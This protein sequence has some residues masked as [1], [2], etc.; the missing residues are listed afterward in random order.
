M[1][2]SRSSRVR[3]IAERQRGLITRRQALGAGMSSAAVRYAT[4][5]QVWQPLLPGI[6]ATFSGPVHA[7]HRTVAALLYVGPDAVL[8][9]PLACRL[10]GL[11]YGPESDDIDVAIPSTQRVRSTG[12]IG[13]HRTDRVPLNTGYA[14]QDDGGIVGPRLA[15]VGAR[16]PLVWLRSPDLVPVMPPARAGLDTVS[17]RK[18]TWSPYRMGADANRRD[19]AQYSIGGRRLD[20]GLLQDTRALLCESV[21]RRLCGPGQLLAELDERDSRGTAHARRA[22]EDITAGCRSAPECELRDL[23]RSSRV[24]PEPHWNEPLP[25]EPRLVPDACWPEARL[26]VEVDS[27]AWHGFGNSPE[28]TE[29]RRASLAGRGWRVLPIA[30]TRIRRE[31]TAVLTEIE[32]AYRAGSAG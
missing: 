30:P 4:N 10:H 12:F 1:G 16:D 9:G 19:I 28:M 18:R 7:S 2:S 11:T 27:R 15:P 14:R 29:R 5:S 24:L 23:I 8:T 13:V 21:Q 25:G 31:S 20:A 22:L 6:Y 3:R 17:V 26:V 32:T